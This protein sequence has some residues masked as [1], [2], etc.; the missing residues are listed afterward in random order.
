MLE[1][2]LRLVHYPH[3]CFLLQVPLK[4]EQ[5]DVEEVVGDQEEGHEESVHTDQDQSARREICQRHDDQDQQDV[6]LGARKLQR[7]HDQA[8][9]STSSTLHFTWA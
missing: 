9:R 8:W 4:E 1:R 2:R 5:E 6:H 7:S 3:L